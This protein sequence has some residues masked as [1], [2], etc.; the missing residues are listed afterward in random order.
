M[1][2]TPAQMLVDAVGEDRAVSVML[3]LSDIY[4]LHALE[5]DGKLLSPSVEWLLDSL[6]HELMDVEA[7]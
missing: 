4:D 6:R 2:T 1:N 7:P 5:V 3:W